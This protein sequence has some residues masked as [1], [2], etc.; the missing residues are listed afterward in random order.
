LVDQKIIESDLN[1]LEKL[2]KVFFKGKY[3]KIN[4]ING[5]DWETIK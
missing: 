5:N 1:D 4:E 3:V 2:K